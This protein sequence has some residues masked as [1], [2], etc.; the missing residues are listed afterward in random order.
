MCLR[1]RE[2]CPNVQISFL[3]LP[4]CIKAQKQCEPEVGGASSSSSF[5]PYSIHDSRPVPFLRLFFPE[6]RIV[7]YR[8]I[9]YK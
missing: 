9:G 3:L 6:Q 1:M 2:A 4:F 5:L 7:A 8:V